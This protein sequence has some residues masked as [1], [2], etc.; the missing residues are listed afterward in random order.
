MEVDTHTAS[1][2]KGDATT[3]SLPVTEPNIA[4]VTDGSGHSDIGIVAVD[5]Q[6]GN[7]VIHVLNKV[8]LP[9]VK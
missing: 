7:D 4:D 1:T 9:V 6:V 8:I 5:V 3:I 2:L